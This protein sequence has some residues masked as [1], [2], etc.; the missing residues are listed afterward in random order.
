MMFHTTYSTFTYLIY[1]SLPCHLAIFSHMIYSPHRT[2]IP[3]HQHV[4]PHTVI[5]SGIDSISTKSYHQFDT[6]PTY[7]ITYLAIPYHTHSVPT[8]PEGLNL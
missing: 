2:T 1:W 4:V 5:F 8:S 3:Y 7:D 6:I